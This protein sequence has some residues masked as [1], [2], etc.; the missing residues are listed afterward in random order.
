MG[1]APDLG[2]RYSIDRRNNQPNDEVSGGGDVGEEMRLGG[3]CGG[4]RLFV[5]LGGELS[6]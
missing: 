1:G 2:G 3:T 4:G 6:D 5:V